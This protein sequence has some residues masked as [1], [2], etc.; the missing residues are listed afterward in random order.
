M[1]LLQFQGPSE[2]TVRMLLKTDCS[3]LQ[4]LLEVVLC[5]QTK[6]RQLHLQSL[7]YCWDT[8]TSF[9]SPSGSHLFNV[10]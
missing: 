5:K 8:N 7:P 1:N 9:E 3:V 6:F 4:T 10:V 2:D